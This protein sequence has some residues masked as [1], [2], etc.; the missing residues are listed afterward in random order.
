MATPSSKLFEQI[1]FKYPLLKRILSELEPGD[2]RSLLLS[3]QVVP[4]SREEA[5][6]FLISMVCHFCRCNNATRKVFPCVG[7][8]SE[9]P[10]LDIENV[11]SYWSTPTAASHNKCNAHNKWDEHEHLMACCQF[12][13]ETHFGSDRARVMKSISIQLQPLRYRMCKIHCLENFHPP[14]VLPNE[15]CECEAWLQGNGWRCF[16]CLLGAWRC[17]RTRGENFHH[18]LHY[19]QTT[20]TFATQ[21]PTFEYKEDEPSLQETCCMIDCKER[22]WQDVENAAFVM[23]CACCSTVYKEKNTE[24]IQV[25]DT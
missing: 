19:R 10:K 2:F 16:R 5:N 4:M 20:T 6:K 22:V 13:R 11:E 8:L 24:I 1:L 17:L 3:G 23:F 15:K 25:I 21:E 18:A 12:C 14:L 9:P 7:S